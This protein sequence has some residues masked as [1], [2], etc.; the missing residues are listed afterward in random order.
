[1]F[2]LNTITRWMKRYPIIFLDTLFN[3]HGFIIRE[4]LDWFPDHLITY[5]V[6]LPI[7]WAG[8][9]VFGSLIVAYGLARACL[10]AARGFFRRDS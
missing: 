7:W 8:F 4:D 1:M 2:Y 9:M 10:R 5:L 6:T 3:E